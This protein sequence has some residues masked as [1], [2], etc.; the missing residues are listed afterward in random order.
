MSVDVHVG[1]MTEMAWGINWV[2]SLQL[3][4]TSAMTG[5][6]AMCSEKKARATVHV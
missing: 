3:A 5:L 4:M 2:C 6:K 1:G